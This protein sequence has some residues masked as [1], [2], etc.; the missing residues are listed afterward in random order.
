MLFRSVFLSS[1]LRPHLSVSGSLE[2][3]VQTDRRGPGR[4]TCPGWTL[5]A[6]CMHHTVRPGLVLLFFVRD[7]ELVIHHPTL[8]V[9]SE[10]TLRERKR[11]RD[12]GREREVERERKR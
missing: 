11:Q 1:R 5:R 8:S 4:Q 2:G 12:R 7:K 3:P 9:S 10:T 6:G